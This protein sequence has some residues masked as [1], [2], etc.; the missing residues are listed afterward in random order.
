MGKTSSERILG[1]LVEEYGNREWRPRQ[2]PVSVLIQTILSQNTTDRNSGQAFESLLAAFDGWEDMANA[3]IDRIAASIK[4]GG[5]G[6]VKARYIKRALLEIKRERDG[7]EL[8][9]LRNL[10]LG[11]ARDW[12]RQL[13][14]V[15]T[16]TANCVL[17]FALGMPALPVDTHVFRVTRRLGLINSKASVEQAHKLLEGFIPPDDVYQFHVLV[18][19]HGRRV[20]KARH[21]G[22]S[23]CML[24][25]SCASYEELSATERR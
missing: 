4:A 11:K 9:F 16:K 19:E 7:F 2:S 13:P 6:E 20:C 1:L 5:L 24:W 15:G 10:P 23:E 18:I 25:Q 22:C 21:P 8:A 3:S 14:G 12:L 17:L